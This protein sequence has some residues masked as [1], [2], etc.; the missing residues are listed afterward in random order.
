MTVHQY[1]SILAWSG[2]TAGGYAA[3]DRTHDIECAGEI[4]TLSADPAFRGDA[5]L[6]NPEQFLL[7]AA[8][9]CQLLS[10]LAVA[11]LAGIDVVS[12]RDEAMAVMPADSPPMRITR[13]DLAPEIEVRGSD[14]ATVEHLVAEAHDGCYV[15]HSLRADVVVR[16]TVRV[17]E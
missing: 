1:Q 10:F 7:A 17:L 9:S 13:I 14:R 8:S 4:F 12:Y 2:T 16:P 11:A 5:S 6:P 3:Y 15:A